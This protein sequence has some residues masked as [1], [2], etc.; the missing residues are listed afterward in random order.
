MAIHAKRLLASGAI[1]A[2]LLFADRLTKRWAETAL[3]SKGD[4][5]M[6]AIPGLFRF[7]YA[8][9]TGMAF[10]FLSGRAGLLALVSGLLI[11]GI[12][13]YLAVAKRV[14]RTLCLGLSFV[15]AGGAGNLWDRVAQ[16][17]VTDFV[18]LTFMRFAVFNLADAFVCVGAV[19]GVVAILLADRKREARV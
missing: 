9:N 13:L 14:S 11:A 7:Q 17:Y 18:E 1:S 15:L 10:S 2:V 12:A 6:E 5:V 19:L 8:R 16:G 4:G 3:F